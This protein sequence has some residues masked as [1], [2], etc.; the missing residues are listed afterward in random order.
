M[1]LYL[2][3]KLVIIDEFG[4]RPYDRLFH[5]SH[6]VNI[7]GESYRLREK[8]QAELLGPLDLPLDRR[9]SR[10]T[11]LALARYR[12]WRNLSVRPAR[13]GRFAVMSVDTSRQ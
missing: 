10:G 1:P 7:R 9:S 3:P 6:V 5:H 2:A 13:L 11:D 4:A 8:K 12:P